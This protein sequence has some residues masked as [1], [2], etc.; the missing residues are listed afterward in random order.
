MLSNKN[1]KWI[2]LITILILMIICIKRNLLKEFIIVLFLFILINFCYNKYE[3]F[4]EDDD[5]IKVAV[6][7]NSPPAVVKMMTDIA[8]TSNQM[9][10]D[11]QYD[12]V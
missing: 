10:S 2:F 8:I 11:S 4:E 12:T 1:I 7:H 5:G 3:G 9:N 6:A